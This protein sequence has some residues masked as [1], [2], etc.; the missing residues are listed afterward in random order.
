M[1]TKKSDSQNTDVRIGISD[2]NHELR[3]ETAL[4]S[5]QVL[6]LVQD[7]LKNESPLV[8]TDIKNQSTVIPAKKIAFVELGDSP[9][10]RV[11]FTAL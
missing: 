7:A 2:S 3:I 8:I 4:S 9:D 1:A 5:D 11:G 6:A 10:R